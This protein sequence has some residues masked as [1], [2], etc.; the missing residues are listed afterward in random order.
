MTTYTFKPLSQCKEKAIRKEPENIILVAMDYY[1]PG[2][3]AGGPVRSLANLIAVLGEEYRFRV[4]THN[5][6]LGD[7]TPYAGVDGKSWKQVGKAEVFYLGPGL[8]GLLSFLRQMILVDRDT[9]LYL[10][11]FFSRRNSMLPVLLCRLGLCRPGS[12]ILA[13]RGEFSPGALG[14]HHFRKLLFIKLSRALVLHRNVIWHASTSLEAED[15][16]RVFPGLTVLSYEDHGRAAVPAAS[17]SSAIAIAGD[18]GPVEAFGISRK[19]VKQPGQLA[20]LVIARISPMKNLLGALRILADVEGEVQLD[21]Y[22]P[23]EDLYYWEQCKKVIDKLPQNVKV[24]YE[25]EI[26]HSQVQ[27]VFAE[28]DLLFLPTLGEN[29]G[30]VICE[31]L[32]AGCPVLIS[33]RT[34]WRNLYTA[35]VG[36]DLPLDDRKRFVAVLQECMAGDEEWFLELSRRAFDYANARS[37]SPELINENRKLLQLGLHWAQQ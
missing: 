12:I 25:G 24:R 29:Y 17:D 36:W 19:R 27:G 14:I 13:P 26:E 11:S 16:K 10:Y 23:I 35:G 32:M 20:A 15:I 30:H 2:Y 31:S 1:L 7:S 6:D 9:V 3:K 4:L 22:G 34:P 21:I 8:V 5:G 33:D 37:S 18:I 28:H